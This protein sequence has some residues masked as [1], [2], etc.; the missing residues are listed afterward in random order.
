MT[1]TITLER[2]AKRGCES[3]PDY[4]EKLAPQLNDLLY[5]R[6]ARTRISSLTRCEAVYSIVRRFIFLSAL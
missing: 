4:C 2:L 1:T 6:P 3:L 5:A